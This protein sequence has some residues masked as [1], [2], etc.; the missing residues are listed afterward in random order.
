M[1]KGNN[2]QI[3]FNKIIGYFL[4]TTIVDL[5][6]VPKPVDEKVAE[7]LA[8]RRRRAKGRSGQGSRLT[9]ES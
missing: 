2:R 7:A 6:N 3:K 9:K 8:N 4:D 5:Q 1:E